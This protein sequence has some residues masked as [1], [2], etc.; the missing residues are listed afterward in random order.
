MNIEQKTL[1]RLGVGIVIL[2]MLVITA[3]SIAHNNL[4]IAMNLWQNF[5]IFF[6]ILAA[7][8]VAA[9][10]LWRRLRN[11]FALLAASMLGSFLFGVYYHFI[12]IGSDNV[13]TLHDAPW[14]TT[15][16]I[17]A[18]LLALIEFAGTG[19]G[20]LGLVNEPR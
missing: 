8:I 17:S 12:A 7:P 1:G 18:V 5:Y 4:Y 11:G 6:V 13:F 14:T 10:F 2:H 15:F 9:V 16:Q 20:L 19:V 3:H